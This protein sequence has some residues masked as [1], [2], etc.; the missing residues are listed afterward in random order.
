[1]PV[2]NA[3]EMKEKILSILKRRGPSLPVHVSKET[4][5]SILFA[6]A[7]LS[8]LVA[9][10]KIR[11][12][13]MKVGSSPLYYINEHGPLL[14]KFGQYLKSKEKDAF[15]LLKE[16][17]FIRDRDQSPQ[18]RV[19]LRSIRDFAVPFNRNGEIIWRY[20]IIPEAELAPD[21]IK[22]PI[23]EE[24]IVPKIQIIKEEEKPVEI[25]LEKPAG[26]KIE[27][28]KES[29]KEHQKELNIFEKQK[30]ASAK[31]TA[32]KKKLKIDDNFF[33]KVKEWVLNNSMEIIDIQ[34]FNKNE[35]HLKIKKDGKEH[36]LVA[37]NKK[38]VTDSD[39]I[40]ANRKA[41][42]LGLGYAI[43]SFGELQKRISDLI[44]AAKNLSDIKKM[45]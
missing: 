45:E 2:E 31:K 1:M 19:A 30:K 5:L 23:K 44:D 28:T 4:G 18:I 13:D 20:Y 26:I 34:N 37:Y 40:K 21:V 33:N 32:K 10:K 42:D 36:L 29:K 22:L 43:L 11:Y 6:S 39:L 27:K 3:L 7:F 35:L 9:D 25:K 38:R 17:K 12:S 41:K 14:E 16:N 24:P 8:E 15:N